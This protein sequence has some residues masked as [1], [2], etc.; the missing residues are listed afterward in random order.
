MLAVKIPATSSVERKVITWLD[1]ASLDLQGDSQLTN[2]L[3]ASEDLTGHTHPVMLTPR[4]PSRHTFRPMRIPEDHYFMMGDNRDNS[5]DSRFFGL[6]ARRNI[7][8]KALRIVLSW[9][10]SILHPR[11]ERFFK[12]LI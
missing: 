10:G 11:T 5:A 9:E 3:F 8:G 2:H 6:V 1:P 12:E 7:V 4:R